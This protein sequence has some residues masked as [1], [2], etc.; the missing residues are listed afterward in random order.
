MTDC[1]QEIG[2]LQSINSGKHLPQSP[3]TSRFFYMAT[4]CIGFYMSYLSTP[5]SKE[6]N[7]FGF[8]LQQGCF[9]YKWNDLGVQ[10][11]FLWNG[12][13]LVRNIEDQSF[14]SSNMNQKH[15]SPIIFFLKE[16]ET[17]ESSN[18]FSK[19]KRTWESSPFLLTCNRGMGVQSFSFDMQQRNGS[20]VVFFWHETE[21]WKSSLF[22]CNETET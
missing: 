2:Y 8:S 7:D 18:F 5:L 20:P 6:I 11:F 4:F 13:K 9:L 21:S 3:S 12:N 1:T 14:F 15:G 10:S 22:L 16:T 17:W 19:W